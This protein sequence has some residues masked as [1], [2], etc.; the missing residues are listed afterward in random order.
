LLLAGS[1]VGV[2]RDQVHVC[3]P[4]GVVSKKNG[5][6]RL[7]LD[8][9]ILN[10]HLTKRTFKFE[11]LRVVAEILQPGDWFFTFDLPNC[12]HHVDIF[13]EH[14]KYFAFSFTFDGKPRYFLFCSLPFGLSTSPYVFQIIET[15]CCTLAVARH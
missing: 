6:L 7:I 8:L 12:Y 13:Q 5:K 4:L 3:R 9:R 14:W 10:K 15:S 11:D 1:A 2:K